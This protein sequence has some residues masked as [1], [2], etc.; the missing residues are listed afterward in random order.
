[1]GKN[2]SPCIDICK[3]RDDGHCVGCS[4]TKTQKKKSKKLKSKD[5]QL[6]FEGLV[7]IQQNA[8]GGFEA[9]ENAHEKKYRDKD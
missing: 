4:M 9:W 1:M 3:F 5:E 7:R 6:A 8:L 2:Y